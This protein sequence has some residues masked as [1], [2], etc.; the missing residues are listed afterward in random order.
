MLCFNTGSGSCAK[1]AKEHPTKA[2]EINNF[3]HNNWNIR[4]DLNFA[5]QEGL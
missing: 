4:Q 2:K 5:M 3:F 1:E